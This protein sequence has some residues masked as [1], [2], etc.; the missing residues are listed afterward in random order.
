VTALG[1]L[2]LAVF[3]VTYVLI[4]TEWVHRV[5]AAV[6]GAVIVLLIGAT[7]P[8]RA[9]YSSH[10]GIDWDVVFL[11]LG[12]MLIVAVLQRTGGFEWTALWALRR[13]H[14]RPFAALAMVVVTSSVASA[15]LDNV[16]TV[17]L[18]APITIE[19]CERLRVRPV[20]YLIAVAMASNIGG[21]ATLVGDPPNIIIASRARLSYLDFLVH[22]APLAI[23]LTAVFVGLCWL[24]F[25]PRP[26]DGTDGAEPV[27][28]TGQ[29]V[30]RDRA[31]LIK[32]IAVLSVVTAAFAFHTML[33]LEPSVIALS[34]GLILLGISGL[35]PA[36]VVADIE[37]STLV[38][39]AGLF[40][41]IG[42]LVETGVIDLVAQEASTLADGRPVASVFGLLWLSAILSAFIDNIPYV[43]TMAP[44]V[45]EVTASSGAGNELWWV[46]AMG[47]DLGG[48]ATPVGA[49][50]NVV[51]TGYAAKAGHPISF[52]EFT[53]YGLIVAT[54]TVAACMP[55]VWLR[56]LAGG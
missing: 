38:F 23:V 33:G 21:M 12:M 43:A 4:A 48:N 2:S 35:E 19:V 24:L 6:G 28:L 50:A 51:I 34:G 47:A 52:W 45:S 46:L 8:H 10:T 14:G 17:L 32:G 22:L 49:S 9:F 3:A 53:K 7:D 30:V 54:V 56:Y 13:A 42:S 55:Y 15:V 20:P 25:R 37:W 26:T 18:L 40:V 29:G 41:I 44:V 16:T 11:L 36:E 31:L 5:A 27:D 39:F 1:W